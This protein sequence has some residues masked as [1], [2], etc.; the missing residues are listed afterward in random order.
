MWSYS[1]F[2]IVG[3]KVFQL[4]PYPGFDVTLIML[5]AVSIADS[6]GCAELLKMHF[7]LSSVIVYAVLI[8]QIPCIE[9]CTCLE[10]SHINKAGLAQRFYWLGLSLKNCST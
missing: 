5:N 7:G 1:I 8:V 10:M 3:D 2:I 6:L 9:K 4:W